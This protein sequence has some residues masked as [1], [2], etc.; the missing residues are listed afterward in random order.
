M[1]CPSDQEA[2]RMRHVWR[3][4]LRLEVERV[5]PNIYSLGSLFE[6]QLHKDRCPQDFTR[7]YIDKVKA[8]IYVHCPVAWQQYLDDIV[9]FDAVP[10]GDVAGEG[11]A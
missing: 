10:A 2:A 8:F 1:S 11:V 9:A 5:H 3:S 4:W 6:A 7:E